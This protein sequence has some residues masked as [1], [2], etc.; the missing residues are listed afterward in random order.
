MTPLP[1]D[2]PSPT[3]DDHDKRPETLFSIRTPRLLLRPFTQ[4]DFDAVHAYATDAAVVRF[5]DWGPNTP[6]ETQTALD[7]FSEAQLHRSLTDV[8]LAIHHVADARA[9]WIDPIERKQPGHAHR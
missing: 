4:D 3:G 1:A 2:G 9:I 5:M 7:R 8:N 6:E